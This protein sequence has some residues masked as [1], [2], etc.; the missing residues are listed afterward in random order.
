MKKVQTFEEF[1]NEADNQLKSMIHDQIEEYGG[2]DD[3]SLNVK[4]DMITVGHTKINRKYMKEVEEELIHPLIEKLN[5][6]DFGSLGTFVLA[7]QSDKHF[8]LIAR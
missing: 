1:L 6:W 7:E 5:D 8:M 4:K 2:F 3:F